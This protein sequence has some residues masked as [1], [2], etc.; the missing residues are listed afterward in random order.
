MWYVGQKVVAI[1]NH[2]EGLFSIGETYTITLVGTECYCP[3]LL[4]I[5][6]Q[7]RNS[8]HI[9]YTQCQH[10]RCLIWRKGGSHESMFDPISFRPLDALSE[11][12]EQIESEGAPVELEHA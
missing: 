9:G 8:G 11:Q 10:C 2:S 3:L 12:I 1:R 5:G 6:I 4:G 7:S